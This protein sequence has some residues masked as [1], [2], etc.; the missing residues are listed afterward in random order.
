MES[1]SQIPMNRFLHSEAMTRVLMDRLTTE[2]EIAVRRLAK[3]LIKDGERIGMLSGKS[4]MAAWT[5]LEMF[6]VHEKILGIKQGG[7]PKP[8]SLAWLDLERE[9]VK[10][11]DDGDFMFFRFRQ[12]AKFLLNQD[13]GVLVL[14]QLE[15]VSKYDPWA[16]LARFQKAEI[17]VDKEAICAPIL[18]GTLNFRFK[19]LDLTLF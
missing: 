19:L 15:V 10:A 6:L 17:S 12:A 13:Q 9:L 7:K 14:K 18:E 4:P 16:M 2:G 8:I 1:D 3:K 11:T 5:L